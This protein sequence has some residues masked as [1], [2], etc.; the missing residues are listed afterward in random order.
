MI[1]KAP[2]PS[3]AVGVAWIGSVGIMA[4]HVPGTSKVPGKF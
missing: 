1:E 4:F 3:N 2:R